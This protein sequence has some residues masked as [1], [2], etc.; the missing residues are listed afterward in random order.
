MQY[1]HEYLPWEECG[2]VVDIPS[3]DGYTDEE[4]TDSEGDIDLTVP[5]EC[6]MWNSYHL[7][8]LTI[9]LGSYC[10]ADGLSDNETEAT[11]QNVPIV[12]IMYCIVSLNCSSCPFIGWSTL[13]YEMASVLVSL[14]NL[15]H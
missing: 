15:H 2:R 11:K 9:S 8:I 12:L 6:G 5:S 4:V 1:D 14:C 7:L 3:D 10:S 13:L